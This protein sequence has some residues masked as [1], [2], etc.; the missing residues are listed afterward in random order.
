MITA[1]RNGCWKV[2]N[3]VWIFKSFINSPSFKYYMPDA[4]REA[5]S[6][7]EPLLKNIYQV[8]IMLQEL[9]KHNKQSIK[10]RNS[11]IYLGA[12]NRLK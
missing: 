10:A 8:P 12:Q 11:L 3:T 5:L 1:P 2:S 9:K 7:V 4:L 6:K